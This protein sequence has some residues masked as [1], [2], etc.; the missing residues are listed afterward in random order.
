MP[1]KSK[2]MDLKVAHVATGLV[3]LYAVTGAILVILSATVD[4][5]DPALKISFKAYLDQ[6]A[7]AVA[8]L[9]IGRGLNSGLSK[10]P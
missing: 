4:G 3:L 9:A 10:R 1:R 6:M 7:V 2:K 5:M 8:G